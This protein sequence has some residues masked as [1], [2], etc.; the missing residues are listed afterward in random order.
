MHVRMCAPLRQPICS[1]V[2]WNIVVARNPLKDDGNPVFRVCEQCLRVG[3][4]IGMV[5]GIALVVG[6]TTPFLMFA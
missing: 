4:E 2:P 3:N 1:F 6:E 5:K